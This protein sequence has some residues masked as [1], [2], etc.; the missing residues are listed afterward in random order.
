LPIYLFGNL[1]CLGMCG[2]LVF[3]LGQH[4]YRYFYFIGRLLSFTLA[5]MVAGEVGFLINAFF[6]HYHISAAASA[7]FGAI[8][9]GTGVCSLQGWHP[10]QVWLTPSLAKI[11]RNLSLLML[12]DQPL[13]TFLFG[14]FTL[15]LPCGQTI[16]VYSACALS[17]DLWIGM[18]NGLAFALLTSPSLFLAMAAHKLFSRAKYYHRIILGG[19]AFV[20]G[21][22]AFCRALA[23]WGVIPHLTFAL[24]HKEGV[25]F[26]IY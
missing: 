14:F 2:P 5:G 18:I 17:G 6:Q 25:H 19:A 20:I 23:E 24:T 13:P 16:I 9:M 7:V 4:R 12:K 26:V 8:M 15:A 3:M 11:N 1:H 21:A 10:G 22:L